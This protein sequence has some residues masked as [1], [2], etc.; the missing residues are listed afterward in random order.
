MSTRT[1]GAQ[2]R[3]GEPIGVHLNFQVSIT[4]SLARYGKVLSRRWS[5]YRD[6]RISLGQFGGAVLTCDGGMMIDDD[7]AYP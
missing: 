3:S 4:A 1:R 7:E 6:I 5:S 2:P